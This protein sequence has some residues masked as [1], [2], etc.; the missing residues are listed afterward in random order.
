M[1]LTKM[2]LTN[3]IIAILIGLQT[4]PVLASTA[5]SGAVS[6]EYRWLTFVVFS[7]IIAAT[8]YIT[9]WASKRVKSAADFYAAGNSI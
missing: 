6:A 4:A 8:M 9:Y 2:R 5:S 1:C 3:P 7:S